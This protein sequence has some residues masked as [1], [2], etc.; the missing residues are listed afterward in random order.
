MKLCAYVAG[1]LG[2]VTAE[3]VRMLDVINL[4]FGVLR[5]GVLFYADAEEAKAAIL[6]WKEAN[7]SLSVLLSVGG[8]GA[9]SVSTTTGISGATNFCPKSTGASRGAGR[10]CAA[11]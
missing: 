2:E 7:P 6:R 3:D 1:H 5:D 8:W 9:V 11:R 10:G 4:A